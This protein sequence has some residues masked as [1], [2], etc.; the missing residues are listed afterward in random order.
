MVNSFLN[1]VFRLFDRLP[2]YQEIKL[3]FSIWLYFGVGFQNL[4]TRIV[5][6]AYQT[7]SNVFGHLMSIT[8]IV[9]MNF[10]HIFWNSK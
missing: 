6:P 3:C 5:Q 2:L 9:F 1:V 8:D 10:G 4:H 7:T